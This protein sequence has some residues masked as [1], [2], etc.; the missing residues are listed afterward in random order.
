MNALIDDD[1]TMM[2]HRIVSSFAFI[3]SSSAQVFVHVDHSS[4]D[5][6]R[7]SLCIVIMTLLGAGSLDRNVQSLNVT[8]V[9]MYNRASLSVLWCIWRFIT[10]C[11]STPC[12]NQSSVQRRVPRSLNSIEH[13]AEFNV[14]ESQYIIPSSKTTQSS[15]LTVVRSS[16]IVIIE[17]CMMYR[18]KISYTFNHWTYNF[19]C[20]SIH[21]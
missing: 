2:N 15:S 16:S 14:Y 5:H 18:Y 13:S 3:D 4:I 19:L 10:W 21:W 12:I 20:N 9:V 8:H 17:G 6:Q 7:W 1:H 11:D